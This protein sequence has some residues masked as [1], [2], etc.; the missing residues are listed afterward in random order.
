VKRLP[1]IVF[2]CFL[3]AASTGV[4]S[5][6]P[7]SLSDA[8]AAIQANLRTSDGKAFD[9]RMGKEFVD[10]HLAALR[11]CKTSAGGDLSS[12]WILLKLNNDGTAGEL[13]LYPSTKLGLCAR[14]GLLKER[15][16]APPR[17]GYWVGIYMNL[18]H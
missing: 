6:K 12:F 17:T 5:D 4:A 8:Q 16:L 1:E 13:L 3:L 15:F 18:G 14:E 10:K 9:D 11:Q 2:F 7:T